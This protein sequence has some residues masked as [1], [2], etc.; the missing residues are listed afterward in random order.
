MRQIPL[1]FKTIEEI[2]GNK[3]FLELWNA[4]NFDGTPTYDIWQ[5]IP[6]MGGGEFVLS[7]VGHVLQ[8]S[9]L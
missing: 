4:T 5:I 2:R 6:G 3:K 9:K 1:E 8:F 7:D